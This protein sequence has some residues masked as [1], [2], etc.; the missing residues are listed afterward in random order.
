MMTGCMDSEAGN[1]DSGATTNTLLSCIYTD[2][3]SETCSGESDG[4]GYIVDNDID[5]DGV[6]DQNEIDGCTNLEA[7]NFNP[8]A[9]TDD[10]S[11]WYQDDCNAGFCFTEDFEFNPFPA[12]KSL[13]KLVPDPF[14]AT[15][16][17]SIS[18]GG[19][20]LV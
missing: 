19:L 6:C 11:C 2:G 4:T 16:I 3:V 13:L 17:T 7:C 9:N 12:T 15:N 14:G 20:I 5:D 10:G 8:D 18:L 1:Y